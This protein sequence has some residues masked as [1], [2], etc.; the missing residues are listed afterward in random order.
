[1]EV[2]SSQASSYPMGLNL[3]SRQF[4]RLQT[5]EKY[6]ENSRVVGYRWFPWHDGLY[7][8]PFVQTRDGVVELQ[9]GGRLH[10]IEEAS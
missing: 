2:E 10:Q 4:G 3:T 5:L 1:M 7:M 9:P 8:C 6:D